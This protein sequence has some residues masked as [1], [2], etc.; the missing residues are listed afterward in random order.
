MKLKQLI[1]SKGINAQTMFNLLAVIVLS[2]INFFTMPIYTRMLGTANYGVY[3]LYFTWMTFFNSFI[4]L[5]VGS[6]IVVAHTQI[7]T[8]KFPS[9]RSSIL[10]LGTFFTVFFSCIAA[11][12]LKQFAILIGLSQG[13]IILMIFHAYANSIISF[14]TNNF[15]FTKNAIVRFGI[16]VIVALASSIASIIIIM[17]L[18]YE[19]NYYGRIIGTV[20]IYIV[21]AVGLLIYFFKKSRPHYN[22]KYWKFCLPLAW[23]MIFHILSHNVLTQSDKVMMQWYGISLS[24]IGIYGFVYSFTNIV[25]VFL[26]ALYTSWLPYFYDYLKDKSYDILKEK[27]QNYITL[28]SAAS[29]IFLLLSREVCHFFAPEDYWSGIALIPILI[30]AIYFIFLYQFPVS[31]EFYYH[32]TKIIAIC[33]CL[34]AIVNIMLNSILIPRYSMFGAGIA[35]VASY[36]LLYLAHLFFVKHIF[37]EDYVFSLKLF[38]PGSLSVVLAS[39]LFYLLADYWQIRWVLGLMLAVWSIQKTI[40]RK[41]IF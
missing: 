20:G 37:G 41:S 4:C 17:H 3:T 33:T 40:K 9:Y 1:V 30:A 34:A 21:V 39:I 19:S 32:K 2:G 12:F 13:L 25:F 6:T 31:F 26:D 16:S 36:F 28:F 38:L 22:K 8:E 23:P 14:S 10:M 15:I 11:F 29:C 27:V 35:S 7:E 24:E 18:P 5:Q